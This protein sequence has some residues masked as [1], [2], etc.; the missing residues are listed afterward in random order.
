MRFYQNLHGENH[1]QLHLQ[2]NKL[3][4]NFEKN[5]EKSEDKSL[6][7]SDFTK[8]E[9]KK[10]LL[11]GVVLVT[12]SQCSGCFAL[13]N[14]TANIFEEAGSSLSPN[15][16]AIIVGVIQL[17]GS[18]FPIVLADRAGRK[19]SKKRLFQLILLSNL[20]YLF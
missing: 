5:I 19:V 17:I 3:K 4:S 10:A 13:I 2:I 18:Y 16:S 7:W 9:A 20:K 14:Y 8:K 12:L 15:E 1:E 6:R 11:I